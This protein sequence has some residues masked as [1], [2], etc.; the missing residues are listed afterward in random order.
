V[1]PPLT[2]TISGFVN[3][4]TEAVLTAKVIDTTTATATSPTGLY[5]ITPGSGSAANY[6]FVY[7]PGV[8]NVGPR[9]LIVTANPASKVYGNA[10]PPLTHTIT[11]FV[12]GDTEAVLTMKVVDTTAATAASP[13]GTYA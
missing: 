7:M 13:V 4:D 3:G 10:V 2:H 11:G 12:N 8:L 6:A 9:T 1:V 5:P